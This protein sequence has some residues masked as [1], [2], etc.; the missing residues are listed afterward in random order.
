M[1]PALIKTTIWNNQKI[2]VYLWGSPYRTSE[3]VLYLSDNN[4][5]I[6]VGNSSKE[7]PEYF[8]EWDYKLMPDSIT[9]D[10][11]I[12]KALAHLNKQ[13]KTQIPPNTILPLQKSGL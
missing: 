3:V 7:M 10:Y 12:E 2:E 6:K 4:K 9:N 11:I 1:H 8:G 13:L 5:D